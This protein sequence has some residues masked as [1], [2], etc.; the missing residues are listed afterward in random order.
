M[1]RGSGP[2][3]L[4]VEKKCKKPKKNKN[5]RS[6]KRGDSQ[7][8]RCVVLAAFSARI[9]SEGPSFLRRGSRH[10]HVGP[11]KKLR[12]Q[13]LKPQKCRTNKKVKNPC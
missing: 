6:S 10:K 1:G 12:I 8:L 5:V 2:K 11:T 4:R 7:K 13:G 3:M 9:F